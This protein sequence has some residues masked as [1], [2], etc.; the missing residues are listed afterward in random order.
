VKHLEYKESIAYA[1][2][3]NKCKL[4]QVPTSSALCK[5]QPVLTFL[6]EVANFM[7]SGVVAL[8]GRVLSEICGAS[9]KEEQG[10]AR[11]ATDPVRRA[12][13]ARGFRE[14][15]IGGKY[16]CLSRGFTFSTLPNWA[17]RRGEIMQN[18]MVKQIPHIL[19]QEFPVQ[20][21]SVSWRR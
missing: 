11:E 15:I 8:R 21:I 20:R 3:V 4:L 9:F 19:G 5:L 2:I 10:G 16:V 18:R 12:Y 17:I 14:E 7:E 13:F 1:N 6:V